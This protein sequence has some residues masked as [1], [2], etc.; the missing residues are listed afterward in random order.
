M[1]ADRFWRLFNEG[2]AASRRRRDGGHKPP[3]RTKE[4]RAIWCAGYHGRER[5]IAKL[6]SMLVG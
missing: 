1:A 3:Y 2:Q 4:E 6:Y 5:H